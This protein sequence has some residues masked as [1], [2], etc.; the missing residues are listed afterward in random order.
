MGQPERQTVISRC[1]AYHGSDHGRRQPRR[2]DRRCTRRADLPIPG[3]VHIRQPYWFGE[4]GD[5]TPEAFGLR[6]ASA[7]EEKI[8]ELG[9]EKVAAFI[10]EPVQGAGGVIIPPRDLLA[11][12]PAHLPRVRHPAG[13]RRGDLRLR[14]HRPLVRLASTSASSP[15]S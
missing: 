9:P 6:R 15:T 12:D 8:L 4:G 7:L 1:N 2:H 10:G 14:P 13:R 3:I 11:G 5:M